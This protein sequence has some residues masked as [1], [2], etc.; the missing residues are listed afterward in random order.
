MSNGKDYK[1]FISTA[2]T[3]VTPL[4]EVEFQGDLTI[5][6]G[7]TIE[8][9]GFKNGALTAQGDDGVSFTVTVGLREPLATAQAKVFEHHDSGAAI[10]AV[11]KGA[12]GSMQFAGTWK[13]AISEI[14]NPVKGIRS[15]EV[16]FSQDGTVTRGTAT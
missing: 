10:Y 1:L 6:L 3:A 11:V 12:T 5:N 7:K 16:Q 13:L 14:P 2:G 4:V 8:R 9:T 15:V